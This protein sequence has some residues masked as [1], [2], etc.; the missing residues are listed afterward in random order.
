MSLDMQ[1]SS[2]AYGVET[3]HAIL[4]M[5]G[6]MD[7]QQQV[8]SKFQSALKDLVHSNL[9]SAVGTTCLYGQHTC[10]QWRRNHNVFS[11]RIDRVSDAVVL[12]VVWLTINASPH[13]ADAVVHKCSTSDRPGALIPVMLSRLCHAE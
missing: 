8:S 1:Q 13:A 9:A 7:V 12:P 6:M 3:K 2:H 5:K 4:T 10:G 11:Q